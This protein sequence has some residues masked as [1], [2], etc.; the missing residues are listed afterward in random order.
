MENMF[1]RMKHS[2]ARHIIKKVKDLPF[3]GMVI[4]VG[5]LDLMKTKKG[6]WNYLPG[7]IRDIISTNHNLTLVFGN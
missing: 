5:S 3:F 1:S 6:R 2:M 4:V 7:Q